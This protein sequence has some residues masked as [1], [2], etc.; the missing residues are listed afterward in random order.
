MYIA[1]NNQRWISSSDGKCEIYFT[2]NAGITKFTQSQFLK[3][4]VYVFSILEA[5]YNT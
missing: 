2:E 5:Y 3:N 4:G 1:C